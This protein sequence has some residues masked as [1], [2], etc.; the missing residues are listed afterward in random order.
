MEK[1]APLE[2]VRAEFAKWSGSARKLEARRMR[3]GSDVHHG[4]QQGETGGA[5]G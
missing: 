3:S 5:R 1:V 4:F 2:A